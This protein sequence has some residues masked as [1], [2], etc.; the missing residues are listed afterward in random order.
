MLLVWVVAINSTRNEK[1]TIKTL[2]DQRKIYIVFMR[3]ISTLGIPWSLCHMEIYL[4]YLDGGNIF[5]ATIMAAHLNAASPCHPSRSTAPIYRLHVRV[6]DHTSSHT[7]SSATTLASSAY[8]Y[9]LTLCHT[10][11]HWQLPR[12]RTILQIQ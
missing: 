8:I 6:G 7:P 3:L 4:S 10:M 9:L 11:L 5:Y 2:E 12:R 1:F